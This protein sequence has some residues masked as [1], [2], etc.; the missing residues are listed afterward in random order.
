MIEKLIE[1]LREFNAERDWDQFHC[2]KNLAMALSI[3]TSEIVEIFQW[4]EDEESS[5]LSPEKIE[6][7]CGEIADVAICLLMLADKLGIDLIKAVGEK[8]EKKRLKYFPEKSKGSGKK[9]K[10]L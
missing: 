2:P 10:D 7:L 9:Y 5:H 3:E 1:R 8:I 6:V 4:V